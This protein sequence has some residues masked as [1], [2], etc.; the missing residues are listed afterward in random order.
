MRKTILQVITSDPEVIA[1]IPATR[2]YQ[3]SAI[4]ETPAKPF[5]IY[6]I[7]G[8][9]PG[10]TRRSSSKEI[11][12]ELW[13][14]DVPGSYLRIDRLLSSL[15]QTFN[16]VIHVSAGEGESIS[17]AAYDSRSPDLEDQ[18]FGTIC[19]SVIFTLVGKGQ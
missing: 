16:A 13:I 5:G 7:S 19:K 17:Q 11:R 10:I 9:G 14:H 4:T 1:E 8:S 12:L 15:E 2:W 18:G 6:R 3:A